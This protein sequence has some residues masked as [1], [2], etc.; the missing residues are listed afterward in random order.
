[1]YKPDYLNN[2]KGFILSE[3]STHAIL[4][5]PH[6]IK[7]YTADSNGKIEIRDKEDSLENVVFSI[8]EFAP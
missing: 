3:I 8:Y 1:V 2:F 7:F 4:D 5:H 6:I